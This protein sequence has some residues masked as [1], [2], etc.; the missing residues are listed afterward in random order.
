MSICVRQQSSCY[1][2]FTVKLLLLGTACRWWYAQ[3]KAEDRLSLSQRLSL[4]SASLLMLSH[5]GMCLHDDNQ[6][7]LIWKAFDKAETSWRVAL[8]TEQ[9]RAI[10]LIIVY[11]FAADLCLTLHVPVIHATFC[12]DCGCDRNSC[13]R[14]MGFL[15]LLISSSL[16]HYSLCHWP[17][18]HLNF[19]L[20]TTH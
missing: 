17:Q 2:L 11:V 13:P 15:P 6:S 4:N 12:V 3:A 5:S 1:L 20:Q 8:K 16:I 14:R 9:E 10:F 19:G 18:Y 7:G